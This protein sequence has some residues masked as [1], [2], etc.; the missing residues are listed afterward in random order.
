MDSKHKPHTYARMT[1]LQ[2]FR[3]RSTTTFSGGKKSYCIPSRPRVQL[4]WQTAWDLL[5]YDREVGHY[6]HVLKALLWGRYDDECFTPDSVGTIGWNLLQN[7]S[8]PIA[9]REFLLPANW[10]EYERQIKRML[11]AYNS[12]RD[13]AGW[14]DI[15]PSDVGS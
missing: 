3:E 12:F 13:P 11:L 10:V 2:Y 6:Y 4:P 1:R 15:F 14:H 5:G 7:E 9:D 8:V